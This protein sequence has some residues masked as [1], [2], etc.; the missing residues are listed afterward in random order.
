MLWRGDDPMCFKS[1]QINLAQIRKVAV[2]T[3]LRLPDA[4]ICIGYFI[5][6]R[7]SPR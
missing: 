6:K 4:A 3:A 2:S 5:A 1:L 7:V